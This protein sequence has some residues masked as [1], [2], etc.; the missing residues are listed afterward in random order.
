M[1]DAFEEKWGYRFRNRELLHHA[2][3]HRSYREGAR[4]DCFDNERLEFL[5]DS[6]INL[7][8]TEMIYRR[9]N[10]LRE[11]DLH[12][13]KAHL[14][15]TDFLADV[16]RSLGLGDLVLLGK[17]EEKNGGRQ[18]R[19][20]LASL[21][22]AIAGA[23]FLDSTFRTSAPV[24]RK[25]YGDYLKSI[26]PQDIR[27]NDY[28]SELQEY[29]Q[30]RGQETPQYRL[31]SSEGQPPH[32]RFKVAVQVGDRDL[33]FGIGPSKRQAEQE[34]ASEA[35]SRLQKVPVQKLSDVFFI[36]QGVGERKTDA[37]EQSVDAGDEA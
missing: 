23:M 28:K 2:L 20:I 14:V 35:L 26:G 3:V 22:E 27:I 5:G 17:G 29:L 13:M 34:A 7:V 24:L 6:V 8:V 31:V 33:A 30:A 10:H 25:F 18:N 11:G 19:K 4:G 32:T 15:S 37:F 16:A 36:T 1:I 12:K 9:F 21:F